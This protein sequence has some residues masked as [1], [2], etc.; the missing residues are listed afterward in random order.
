MKFNAGVINAISA[1]ALFGLS[2]PLAKIFIGEIKPF[3]LAGLLYAGSGFGLLIVIILKKILNL[4]PGGAEAPLK[5]RDWPWLIGATF[6]GGFLGP[7]FLVFGL[8]NSQA[9]TASL[10]LNLEGVFT[11]LIAWFVFMENF[12]KRI[13]AGMLLITAGSAAL[14]WEGNA[15]FMSLTGPLAIVIACLSWAIDNNL[16][17]KI[18]GGDPFHIASIK[19]LIAGSTNLLISFF[20]LNTSFPQYSVMLKSFVVGFFGYGLSL[21]MFVLALRHIGTSR[22]GA[23]FSMAPFFGSI[24]SILIFRENLTAAFCAAFLLMAAGVYCHLSEDHE[25]GHEHE[26]IRHEHLH[27][28]DDMHH[29]HEHEESQGANCAAAHTHVHEHHSVFHTHFHYPDIHHEHEHAK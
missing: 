23:Y 18:S 25:H 13:A 3:M 11:A 19:G 26:Y 17:K 8:S 15:V 22:T 21:V 14:S 28:H 24:A 5:R 27:T 4:N 12:D 10:L 29:E 1:A 7:I 16:T 9:S 6:F 20:I 2:T